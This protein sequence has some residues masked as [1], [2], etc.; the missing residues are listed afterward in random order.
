ALSPHETTI[1]R[2][3]TRQALHDAS[4]A[5][6]DALPDTGVGLTLERQLSAA[7]I[8]GE[9]YGTR[10]TTWLSLSAQGDVTLTE[11]R[12]GPLGRFQGETTLATPARRGD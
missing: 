1:W 12:F 5:E 4:L 9:A 2:R 11:Q 8:L 3:A 6:D 7:F 10:A